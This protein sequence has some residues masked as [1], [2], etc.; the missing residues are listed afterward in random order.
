MMNQFGQARQLL[1][2]VFLMGVVNAGCATVSHAD[3]DKLQKQ[4]SDPLP[5]ETQLDTQTI[6]QAQ[7]DG[8]SPK[9]PEADDVVPAQ[10]Q[11]D[12]P[13]TVQPQEV[14]IPPAQTT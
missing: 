14:E 12:L 2:A 8:T 13:P 3:G 9:P 1:V 11:N 6:L 5:F 4:S 7:N 10:P